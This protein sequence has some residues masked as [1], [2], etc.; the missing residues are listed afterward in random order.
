MFNCLCDMLIEDQQGPR[1]WDYFSV[2]DMLA[3]R[4]AGDMSWVNPLIFQI[5]LMCSVVLVVAGAVMEV[6]RRK[7]R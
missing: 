2:R 7:G 6:R 1:F 3:R 5:M 4:A